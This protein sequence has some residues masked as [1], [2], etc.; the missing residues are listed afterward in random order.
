VALYGE[1]AALCGPA[2]DDPPVRLGVDRG[3]AE[4]LCRA[5]VDQPD[6][7]AALAFLAQAL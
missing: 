3:Q 4:R 6:R 1:Q 5:A 7:H 2:G